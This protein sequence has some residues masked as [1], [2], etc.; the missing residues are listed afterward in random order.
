MTGLPRSFVPPAY[1]YD[2]LRPLAAVAQNHPGG[3][4]DLSIGTPCDEPPLAVVAA[5]AS[6]GA[7]RGYPSGVGS[8][9]LLDAAR[10]L[11]ERRFGVALER[12]SVAAC[13]GTKELVAGL[14]HWLR[15]R[16]PERDTVLYPAVSYPTYAMGALL[17]GCRAVPVGVRE[18]GTLDLESVDA[19]DVG[20]S[21]C[22]WV[23][24]PANPTGA[25]D[26]LAAAARFGRAHDVPVIS[27]ECYAEFTWASRPRTILEHGLAGVLAVHSI[28]K[29]SNCAGLRVGFYAGDPE[30]VDYLSELRRHAGF[31]I[32]GPVQLAG[33]VALEDDVHVE[34]QRAR[35]GERLAQCAEIL[36]SIGAPVELPAG[37]FYLWVPSPPTTLLP[38]TGDPS[39]PADTA[40]WRFASLLAVHGGA[41]VSP[42]ELYGPS[43]DGHVRVALVQPSERIALVG[44][45]LETACSSATPLPAR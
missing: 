23:N 9:R 26:D 30:L 20:R 33:A 11:L 10:A 45:R 43:G 8:D 24:S 5:L 19:D 7:E 6:S 39:D 21:L 38:G 25:L 29:R 41:L 22:L 42:G 12:R 27:D 28:S 17:A 3:M 13:I 18:D 35:Y 2:R 32:P 14:P 37:G 4:V 36:A 16:Q 44:R 31:M 40:D 15:L 34:R 1:P